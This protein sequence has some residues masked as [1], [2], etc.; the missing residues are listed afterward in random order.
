[1]LDQTG[2]FDQEYEGRRAAVHDRHLAAVQLDNR[3]VD[4]AAE[5]R[6]HQMFDRGDPHAARVLQGR[7]EGGFDGVVPQRGDFHGVAR[8]IGA[9]EHD[10]GVYI[11]RM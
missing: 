6:R 1:L 7:A 8:G 4:S 9:P 5:H 2:T 3:V 10:A 11:A